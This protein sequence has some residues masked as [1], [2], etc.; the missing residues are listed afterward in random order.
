M[1]FLSI[2][3]AHSFIITVFTAFPGFDAHAILL[4]G[5]AAQQMLPVQASSHAVRLW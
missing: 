3:V 1:L 2:T 5:V 4:H